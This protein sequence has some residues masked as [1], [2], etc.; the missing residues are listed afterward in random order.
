MRGEPDGRIQI[1]WN[2]RYK[3]WDLV[4]TNTH[5]PG[6]GCST[7]HLSANTQVPLDAG[8]LWLVLKAVQEALEAQLI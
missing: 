5:R 1:Y 6:L 7:W 3:R 4:A 8:T 2:E